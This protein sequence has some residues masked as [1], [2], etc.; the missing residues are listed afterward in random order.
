MKRRAARIAVAPAVVDEVGLLR[1]A[2]SAKLASAAAR[3][4]LPD[5]NVAVLLLEAEEAF[6]RTKAE[7]ASGQ[8][9]ES[10]PRLRQNVDQVIE[11]LRVCLSDLDRLESENTN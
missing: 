9:V 1:E 2:R 3:V 5:N 4:S 6:N 10:R 7:W 11:W 8:H